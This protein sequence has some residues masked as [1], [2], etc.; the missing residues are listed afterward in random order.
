[1]S[2][3]K[4]HPTVP[5]FYLRGFADGERI[6][7]VRLPGDQPFMQS[8]RKA[9]S[10]MNFYSIAGH[11]D[12]PDVF[13]KLL[14]SIEGEAS[15]VFGHIADG[16]WPLERRIVGRSLTSLPSKP[17]A[18]RNSGET[19]SISPHRWPGSRLVSGGVLACRI[20]WH[21]TGESPSLKSRRH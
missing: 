15:R 8:V 1:V 17:S 9:A 20:G 16:T 6:A 3:A 10:E 7:T 14:S 21:A 19:W 13:E 12:G 5:Q 11:E 18:V 2:V 4:R